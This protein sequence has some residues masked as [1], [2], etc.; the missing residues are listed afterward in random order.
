M[1]TL[2]LLDINTVSH[3]IKRHQQVTQ[4]L[5]AV[6]IYSVC[7][8][9][10]MAGEVALGLAKRPDAVT[11]KTTVNE[12]MQRVGVL[13][14]DEAVARTYGTLRVQLQSKG[15]PISV[16]DTQIAAHAMHTNAIMVTSDN[17]F[18]QIQDLK[19]EKWSN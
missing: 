12:F 4:R 13:P 18:N 6:P 11:L 10:I 9:A 16:L 1:T 19:Y 5:L 14:C 17:A 3:L 15:T 7:I 8:S 2:Y